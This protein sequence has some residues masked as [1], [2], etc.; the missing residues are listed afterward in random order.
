MCRSSGSL[1]S[2]S[3]DYAIVERQWMLSGL[4]RLHGLRS[5]A[6]GHARIAAQFARKGSRLLRAAERILR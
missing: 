4:A 2:A 6:V 1:A 5:A 3:Y